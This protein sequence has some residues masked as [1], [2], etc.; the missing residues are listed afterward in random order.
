MA[1]C[2]DGCSTGPV[3][4]QRS[5]EIRVADEV[6][7]DIATYVVPELEYFHDVAL[8]R[9]GVRMSC[10]T[11]RLATS[12]GEP[13]GIV[14]INANLIGPFLCCHGGFLTRVVEWSLRGAT[15]AGLVILCGLGCLACSA[16]GKELLDDSI[17][18][19]PRATYSQKYTYLR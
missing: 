3:A 6:T 11:D 18:S 8:A 4:S 12:C 13:A 17:V 9:P 5:T 7:T 16:C 10:R 14:S 19:A 2:M 15:K 1:V